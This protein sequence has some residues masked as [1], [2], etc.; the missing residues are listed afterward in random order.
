MK[1]QWCGV[2][3]LVLFTA[4]LEEGNTGSKKL[5]EISGMKSMRRQYKVNLLVGEA[6][7][8]CLEYFCSA[9][10]RK[11]FSDR[12][13]IF[14][15]SVCREYFPVWREGNGGMGEYFLLGLK[16][17]SLLSNSHLSRAW[18]AF[19]D[20]EVWVPFLAWVSLGYKFEVFV[21]NGGNLSNSMQR[22]ML[23][24]Q[25]RWYTVKLHT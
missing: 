6:G 2:F 17:R 18:G 12:H 24:Q 20:I 9:K 15:T 11:Y 4:H 13:I 22:W 3:F 7:A 25:T 21:G 5:S 8:Y 1:I 14:V 10:S 16:K 19:R 23:S